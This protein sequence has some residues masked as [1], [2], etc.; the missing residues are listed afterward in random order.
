ND[1]FKSLG[2]ADEESQKWKQYHEGIVKILE[3]MFE[4]MA[5]KSDMNIFK[6][7]L[8]GSSAENLKNYSFEDVGDLDLL[9]FPGEDYVVDENMLEYSH[10][11]TAYVKVRGEGHPFL[12]STLTEGVDYVSASDVKELYPAVDVFRFGFTFFPLIA[13][14][15]ASRLSEQSHID[16]RVRE[17]SDSPAVTCDFSF[18]ADSRHILS[19][20]LEQLK[21]L[22][23]H[24]LDPSDLE[25]VPACLCA[26]RKVDYTPQHA[27]VFDD[28]M[29][30]AKDS[31]Q[32]LC[33]NP[34][35]IF[36][37]MPNF[38]RDIWYS[39]RAKE[40]RNRITTLERGFQIES[41]SKPKS[42]SATVVT[43]ENLVVDEN[44][45]KWSKYGQVE[46]LTSS[47][48]F[49]EQAKVV[50]G[51]D[52]EGIEGC[53]GGKNLSSNNDISKA[54][55]LVHECVIAESDGNLGHLAELSEIQYT[56]Q[57][58]ESGI[59]GLF[60][61]EQLEEFFEW[62]ME[63]K[64]EDL[65]RF[66][67]TVEPPKGVSFPTEESVNKHTQMFSID[68]VP[69]L[70]ARGWPKVAREW[71]NRKRKWPSRDTIH[72]IIQDGFHIVVKPPKSGGCSE[73]DFRLSFSNAEYLLSKDLND[74][75]RQCYRGL[76]KYYSVYLRADPKSLVTYHLKTIFLKTCEETGAEMWT[77]ENR[78]ACM[79]KLLENLHNA[80]A[81]K[82]LMHFFITACNLFDVENIEAPQTLESLAVK[83][84]QF[85]KNPMEFCH[86]LITQ[87]EKRSEGVLSP[88]DALPR[89]HREVT[90][91]HDD[92]DDF[93]KEHMPRRK[94]KAL[95]NATAVNKESEQSSLREQAVQGTVGT[96]M[97]DSI[98]SG[99]ANLQNARFHKLKEEY[100]ETCLKLLTI[101][102]EGRGMEGL[103]PLET[104]LLEDIKELI[105]TYD[106]DP[107]HLFSL[108]EKVWGAV[109]IDM[110][111]NSEVFTKT[112]MLAAMQT[113][114]KKIKNKLSG[115]GVLGS[116][117]D[118]SLFLPVD[119][120]VN[121]Q[122]RFKRVLD[123]MKQNPSKQSIGNMD[124]IPLD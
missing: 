109:Y 41:G 48:D 120:L 62:L 83:V 53:V 124:D 82:R 88:E 75:Q 118:Y 68:I 29:Q 60:S 84:K 18:A 56:R 57:N 31:V 66:L 44:V 19:E 72:R 17:D 102:V 107:W 71:I 121:F 78:T 37:G 95:E 55:R 9:L 70:Q 69:A 106:L 45:N 21:N 86:E 58:Q 114:V 49:A 64:A 22:N 10:T 91:Q 6:A 63:E 67:E 36:H 8:Y 24:N 116:P 108:F 122:K 94:P 35:G 27:E 81:E 103:D 1:F 98:K 28:F 110:I 61:K 40:I 33:T 100:L 87:G 97:D 2:E 16:F 85:M 43:P 15:M 47:T 54:E 104:S 59:L 73:T 96:A 111:V 14:V 79:M 119:G 11:N 105:D 99:K 32:S 5:S 23:F 76:K 26:V 113:S 92:G 38:I 12:E 89:C 112:S 34:S 65:F 25:F 42:K 46:N 77:E 7:R 101:A 4:F 30:I 39:E 80:L 90:T 50:G 115:S 93:G 74:I 52:N 51:S 20:R 13:K 123:G 3:L 117:R